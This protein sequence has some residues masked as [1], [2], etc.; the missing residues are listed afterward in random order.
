MGMLSPHH[1]GHSPQP[2]LHYPH[3]GHHSPG[4][5]NHGARDSSPSERH[6]YEH[7]L[8]YKHGHHDERIHDPH[9]VR[10][11]HSPYDK[12]EKRLEEG[13]HSSA[14]DQPMGI[15]IGEPNTEVRIHGSKIEVKEKGGSKMDDP[16]EAVLKIPDPSKYIK[17]SKKRSNRTP[18][19]SCPNQVEKAKVDDAHHEH[20]KLQEHHEHHVSRSLEHAKVHHEH[21]NEGHADHAQKKRT[22][23]ASPVEGEHKSASKRAPHPG[24][25]TPPL[26]EHAHRPDL[27]SPHHMNHRD[28]FHYAEFYPDRPPS[29]SPFVHHRPGAA[30]PPLHHHRPLSPHHRH[31]RS[32]HRPLSP[33]THVG[34]SP[35]PRIYERNEV[36]PGLHYTEPLSPR[37][38]GPEPH[39]YYP[40]RSRSPYFMDHRSHF[41]DDRPFRDHSPPR[42]GRRSPGPEIRDPHHRPVSP[43]PHGR[44]QLEKYPYV[45]L[46][47]HSPP[48]S[49]DKDP[50]FHDRPP[51]TH[52]GRFPYGHVVEW[53]HA[54]PPHHFRHEMIS[55][56]GRHSPHAIRSP[57][58]RH[59]ERHPPLD[60]ISPHRRHSPHDRKSPRHSPYPFLSFHD[61]KESGSDTATSAHSQASK[62]QHFED[63]ASK[64]T[65]SGGPKDTGNTESPQSTVSESK[66]SDTSVL[67]HGRLHDPP[68]LQHE[69]DKSLQFD[70]PPKLS[71]PPR[72]DPLTKKTDP[73]HLDRTTDRQPLKFYEPARFERKDDKIDRNSV[74]PNKTVPEKRAVIEIPEPQASVIPE[75]KTSTPPRKTIKSLEAKIQGLKERIQQ[76]P[77]KL[78]ANIAKIKSSRLDFISKNLQVSADKS[79]TETDNNSSPSP[80]STNTSVQAHMDSEA[81]HTADTQVSDNTDQPPSETSNAP[82]SD[83]MERDST[84]TSREPTGDSAEPETP[85][86]SEKEENTPILTPLATAATSS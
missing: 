5:D 10:P 20:G 38:R 28:Y 35:P 39:F 48:H 66:I 2:I 75:T 76:K 4:R 49:R 43:P 42:Y 24:R 45:H 30:S 21:G 65:S 41:E 81:D 77:N 60:V 73:P 14:A 18:K 32:P 22:H 29:H 13:A 40:E 56:R 61:K 67:E 80:V 3:H 82:Q 70:V 79:K 1:H 25:R 33:R 7:H 52:E 9:P 19:T 72:L 6:H 54:P 55:P 23:G 34:R 64:P 71:T 37:Y 62:K 44:H 59:G 31:S 68:F 27:H 85:L 78:E 53:D 16:S 74:V 11:R 57:H 12:H 83:S 84:E 47:D 8:L 86:A 15:H 51:H 50:F 36:I 58:E 26:P 46:T 69:R 63:A 17:D